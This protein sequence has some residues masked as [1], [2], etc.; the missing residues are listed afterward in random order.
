[1]HVL[2]EMVIEI[3]MHAFDTGWTGVAIDDTCPPGDSC[4]GYS[5]AE[6]DDYWHYTEM[7]HLLPGTYYVLVDTWPSPECIP[8]FELIFD[9]PPP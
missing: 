2:E 5:T 8:V 4:L 7:V 9:Y 6:G 3:V 1:V